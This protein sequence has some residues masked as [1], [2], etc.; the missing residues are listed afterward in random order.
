MKKDTIGFSELKK[1][2]DRKVEFYNRP[3]FIKDDP[4]SIPH[5]FSKNQD[6]EISGLFAAVFAWGLRK[7][8]INKCSEL[9]SLMDNAPHDFVLNHK[10]KDLK[11]L[12]Q[13]KHR[14]FNTTDLLYFIH[15]LKYYYSEN[16][17]LENAF[18]KHIRKEDE[19]VRNGL[20]GF[21][22]L[23]FSLPDAPSRTKKHIPTPARKSSCKR[24]NMYLRWMV[25][26]DNCGVD[27]GLWKKVSPAQL[28]CPLDLHVERVAR[29]LT[30]LNG[31]Q[32]AW[33]STLQLTKRLCELDVADPVKYDFALFG[34]GVGKND[35]L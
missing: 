29:K 8:I 34:M 20:A 24:I 23:F 21:H 26:S 28:L 2:L 16:N 15:F 33:E 25:R 7:T 17:S 9:M 12:L 1:L 6:I 27:F 13:F 10:D 31:K 3:S 11:R 4:I 30:L 18:A 19:D 5:R 14:T 32:N 22:D 35:E